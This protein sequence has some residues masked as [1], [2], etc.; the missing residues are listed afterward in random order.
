MAFYFAKPTGLRHLA[1]QSLTMT[2]ID[3]PQTGGEGDARTFTIAAE[4][5]EFAVKRRVALRKLERHATARRI[6]RATIVRVRRQRSGREEEDDSGFAQHAGGRVHGSMRRMM[7][8]R[9]TNAWRSAAPMKR[10]RSLTNA[11]TARPSAL[12]IKDNL[13]F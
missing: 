12:R 8:S 1:G 5:T 7:S 4:A 3:P 10:K 6:H 9:S 11:S 2:L 13:Y